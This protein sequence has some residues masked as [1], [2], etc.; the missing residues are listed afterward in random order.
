MLVKS[1]SDQAVYL[2]TQ[3]AYVILHRIILNRCIAY[4]GN[5]NTLD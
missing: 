3:L 5:R 1:P 2:C 4:N